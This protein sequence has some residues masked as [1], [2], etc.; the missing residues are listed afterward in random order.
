MSQKHEE[1]ILN[2]FQCQS[3]EPFWKQCIKFCSKV[4]G[5]QAHTLNTR[6]SI[7]FGVASNHKDLLPEPVRAFLRHAYNCFYHDFSNVDVKDAE[8]H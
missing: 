1:S 2:L 6:N 5:V 3:T 4:L 8:F 7:I